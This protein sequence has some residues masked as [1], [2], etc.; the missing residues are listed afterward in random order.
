MLIYKNTYKSPILDEPISPND[1][2]EQNTLSVEIKMD[3]L[4]V[5]AQ[6]V[7][8][9]RIT[10]MKMHAYNPYANAS[11]GN[12]DE[13]RIP[14]QQQD[15]ILLPCDSYL[16]IEGKII[17]G[18]RAP[19]AATQDVI[20]LDCNSMA[21]LFDEIRYEL[22]GIEIDRCK[23]VGITS[24]MKNLISLTAEE[25]TS[26]GHSGWFLTDHRSTNHFNF[27]VP[28]Q[29]LLG[30]CE[31]YRRVIINARHELVLIRARESTNFIILE[32]RK[33]H[34]SVASFVI[35]FSPYLVL[36]FTNSVI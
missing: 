7:F 32:G 31:D 18:T 25:S 20:G 28:L 16:Y 3:P 13:I 34:S 17:V 22:N 24:S 26:L 21:F 4:D 15:L 6:P 14:I 35:N 5:T 9:N 2:A 27:C 19:D 1:A 30:L 23:N 36:F 12:S 11:L 8:D 29:T 33:N 10:K